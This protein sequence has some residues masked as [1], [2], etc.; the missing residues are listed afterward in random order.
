MTKRAANYRWV[1]V[2]FIFVAIGAQAAYGGDWNFNNQAELTKEKIEAFLERAV[3]HFDTCSQ[4]NFSQ[5]EFDRSKQFLLHTQAK[6]IHGAELS[7]GK[8]YPNHTYW[9]NCKAKIDDM[10]ATPGLEDVILE[11]FIAEHIASNAD[12]T[13]IPDWLWQYMEDQGINATRTPSPNDNGNNHYFHYD[14]FFDSGWPFI[15]QWGS[16]QS[17]PDITRTETQL[18]FRYMLK[19]HIDAGIESIW[20]G[21]LALTG[22]ADTDN[23]ALNELCQYAKGYAAQHA[24]RHGLLITSHV[25]S[26][27]Y[28]GQQ[29][30]DYACY[31]TRMRYT[32]TYAHGLEINTAMPDS[33]VW[34]LIGFVEN[35][36]DIPL[37]LEI[38]NYQCST[39]NECICSGG[40]DEI[41]GFA[42]KTPEQRRAFLEQYYYEIQTWFNVW[43]NKRVYL[44]MPGRRVTCIRYSTDYTDSNPQVPYPQF[45][46]SPYAEHNGEENTIAGLFSGAIPPPGGPAPDSVAAGASGSPPTPWMNE[47]FD[48]YN[49]GDVGGQGN[50]TTVSGRSSATI[51]SLYKVGIGKAL[52]VEAYTTGNKLGNNYSFPPQ[53]NGLQRI[54]FDISYQDNR[55]PEPPPD[56]DIGIIKI[57][58]R[59]ALENADL[60]PGGDIIK[61]YFGSSSFVLYHGD[62]TAE[63]IDTT[64][65]GQ[66]Y[67][68]DLT[69]DLEVGT[70]SV[71][72]DGTEVAGAQNLL[73]RNCQNDGLG[74]FALTAWALGVDL[75]AYIDNLTGSLYIPP[76]QRGDLDGDG[77]VDQE[78]FGLFQGCYSGSGVDY[79]PDCYTSDLDG[80]DDVDQEDF[81]EFAACISGPNKPSDCEQ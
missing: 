54:S 43:C 75:R 12:N 58:I 46:Y 71:A 50:W 18:Y 70:V 31:P 51:Q 10:H 65:E 48:S 24:Y 9:D 17:V 5:T 61:F 69:F 47:V 7:W 32:N 6:F 59:S 78:D 42:Y 26:A 11:G 21:G 2:R 30:L 66:W 63:I 38:D 68:F 4:S 1:L 55:P 40:Y 62:Q 74:G 20:F 14:N 27:I 8:S 37:L 49:D 64:V 81:I 79:P 19:E 39:N 3:V 25:G 41:T 53:Y 16:G 57:H 15:N 52:E 45:S 67:H 56:P 29:L 44:A 60:L 35:S 22:H 76:R 80:D 23:S 13:L 36:A 72:L 77:D 34:G 73:L 28:N 33:S